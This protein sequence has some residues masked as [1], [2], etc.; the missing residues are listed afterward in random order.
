MT[1]TMRIR[2]NR[3][4]TVCHGT[5][6]T[7]TTPRQG[8]LGLPVFCTCV[9]KQV[10]G[11]PGEIELVK[12][13]PTKIE[14]VPFIGWHEVEATY[15]E[16]LSLYPQ[17]LAYPDEYTGICP[18]SAGMRSEDVTVRAASLNEAKQMIW[19]Q[20]VGSRY[21]SR[22]LDGSGRTVWDEHEAAKGSR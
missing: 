5:G 19:A 12:N 6:E 3:N 7:V 4:C 15:T 17:V 21:I 2:P 8:G 1:R 13:E 16:T 9:L 10:H 22:I 14:W 18:S 11:D 20:L